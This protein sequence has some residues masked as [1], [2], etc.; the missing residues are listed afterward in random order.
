MN[1]SGQT[2]YSIIIDRLGTI[3]KWFSMFTSGYFFRKK[4]EITD[5][6]LVSNH[7]LVGLSSEMI[8]LTIPLDAIITGHSER[9]DWPALFL[10]SFQL[11][12]FHR[13]LSLKK[14]KWIQNFSR[15]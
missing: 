4:H 12:T 6:C 5:N 11:P 8:L 15:H 1:V 2:A 3:L 14:P 7:S 10:V 9:D 13:N